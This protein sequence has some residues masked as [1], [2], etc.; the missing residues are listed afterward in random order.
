M[1]VKRLVR[2]MSLLVVFSMLLTPFAAF[3]D[4]PTL[5][6]SD[7]TPE[8][9][10]EV[11][12]YSK[13]LV[14][15]I[16]DL[17]VAP[18]ATYEGGINGLAAT[19]PKVTGQAQ[20]DTTTQA[21]QLYRTYVARQLTAFKAQALQAVPSAQVIYDYDVVLGGVSMI[22]PKDQVDVIRNLDGVKQVYEDQMRFPLTDSSNDF[23]G[24]STIWDELGGQG[25]AGEGVVVGV[26]DTGVWPE[27]PS[28]S[29]PDPNGKAY[30]APPASWHG[31]RCDFVDD[32]I[33]A[34]NPAFQCNNKLIGAAEFLDTYKALTG[35]TAKEF[36]SARDDGG[37]GTHTASTAAGNANVSATL[38][39]INRGVV[40]GVAPRAHVAVYKALGMHGGYSS[41][42][43]AA[44]N[45]AVAD[46]VDVINYSVGG[47]SSDP[48]DDSDALAFLD[49]YAAG[50]FVA[51]SAGNSGPGANTV[52]S[53]GDA[54]WVMTVGASTS[55][56]HF[57][58]TV[59]V[60]GET[61][62]TNSITDTLTLTGA[63][64]TTGIVT[65]TAVVMA[66]NYGD[67]M[68]NSPFPANTFHGEIV[69][70]KRGV[71]ARVTK[72]YNVAQGGAGGMLLYNPVMQGLA[73][74]NHFIPSVHL[75]N[76]NGAL[77]LNFMATHTNTV[78]TF[79]EGM[80]TAV[81]GDKMAAFSS[82]GGT[83]NMFG[84]ARPDITA[85]GVQILA[86]NTPMP[87]EASSGQ[88]GE[89]F[90]S[91]QGT[92]MSSPHIAGAGAL[93]AALHPNWTPGQI[94]SAIMTT[95]KTDGVTKE[96]GTTPADAFDYGSGRVD[97]TKA[98]NPGLTFAPTYMDFATHKTDLWNIN[99]PSV[100]F[101]VLAGVRTVQRTAHSE[102]A[103]DSTWVFSVDAPADVVVTTP[104]TLNVPAGGD[105]LFEI[106]VDATNVPDG[107]TRFAHVYLTNGSLKVHI[108]I[109]LVRQQENI[110]LEKVCS[111]NSGGTGSF[112]DYRFG[113]AITM[114]NYLFSDAIV[115]MVD[116]LPDNMQL[117]S[118]ST[119]GGSEINGDV[120][121][122]GSL[123]A[124]NKPAVSL[125]APYSSA[126]G[127]VSLGG[128]GLTPI[129]NNFSD[130]SIVNFSVPS[131]TYAGDQ[132]TTIG[133]NSNGY[134]VVGGGS[135]RTGLPQVFPNGTPPNNVI[136]PF[137]TDLN[138]EAGGDIYIGVLGTSSKRWIIIEWE[139]IAPWDV[140]AEFYTAQL[141]IE[142]DSSPS[143]TGEIYMV[144]NRVDGLG[145][146]WTRGFDTNNPT[147]GYAAGAE[148]KVGASG[149]YYTDPITV[150]LEIQVVATGEPFG[151]QH[152]V[153]FDMI[154]TQPGNWTNCAVM[155]SNAFDGSSIACD[156]GFTG[157]SQIYL[158]LIFK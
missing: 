82:R 84:V 58:S 24:S 60:T 146:S 5:D 101:P 107:A 40:S 47:A 149:G 157:V 142:T 122:N 140:P 46:G 123:R 136:A 86:G 66:A 115:A 57:I 25:S 32:E 113:C 108:P 76:D 118:G 41:D 15:I 27:H 127:Y 151:G 37:H 22:V 91:I 94:K 4:G 116:E 11:H 71:I 148:D 109:T 104:A 55:D 137:W 102:L 45:Q 154:P 18:L 117:V 33:G 139:N 42:L 96:D 114:T 14:S 28:F 38:L 99:Y 1:S 63:S 77:L 103:V 54:P 43:A 69:V 64:V 111:P 21:S 44:I 125:V 129:T 97:L 141:W 3:A 12:N 49:A 39:G 93:L 67:A 72:S 124:T 7:Y 8:K 88:P 34:G 20:L 98:G 131:F 135:S 155:R 30:A 73:T 128:F 95:A 89:L 156:S 74:D 68:C 81:Q 50:V 158:P 83:A 110:T 52:G 78:A 70:C 112:G 31:T 105:A 10:N 51:T 19:S 87:S 56:R 153:S 59:T 61:T 133:I 132:Y 85:P 53:P 75:E 23:I 120:L 9:I 150:G 79:T 106:T 35:L 65:P 80:A 144:Y 26:V 147:H 16:V 29:D 126:F 13:D 90:Q 145:A 36:D 152:V 143:H 2:V 121:Y 62:G 119:V 6:V 92:S 100:Y 48:Y 17:D 130:D 138:I 134:V